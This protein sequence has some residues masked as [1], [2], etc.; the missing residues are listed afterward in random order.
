MSSKKNRAVKNKSNKLANIKLF[1][2]KLVPKRKGLIL[3]IVLCALGLSLIP[4]SIMTSM[5]TQTISDNNVIRD[6]FSEILL[7][8]KVECEVNFQ[9]LLNQMEEDPLDGLYMDKM[10]TP[11]EIFFAEWANDWF[12]EVQIPLIGDYIESIGARMIG[13]INL[14]EDFPEADLNISSHLN[15]SGIS[16]YQCQELWNPT[17]D[18]SLVSLDPSIWFRMTEGLQDDRFILKLEF[19]LTENQIEMISSWIITSQNTWLRQFAKKDVL[20]LNPLLLIVIMAP[21]IA[22]ISYSV[23]KIRSEILKGRDFNKKKSKVEK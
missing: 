14:D 15:P 11:Q 17:R 6:Q 3:P 18:N 20:T 12:P 23:I 7:N 19:N 8:I 5:S 10:P 16:Q 22:M 2:R 4:I 13:D 9:D 21:G 1:L